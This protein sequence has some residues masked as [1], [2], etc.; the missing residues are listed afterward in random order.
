M[1]EE[2]VEYHRLV[3]FEHFW[4]YVND[5]PG[6]IPTLPQRDYITYIPYNYCLCHHNQKNMFNPALWRGLPI[7]QTPVMGECVL[8]ARNEGLRWLALNDVDERFQVTDEKVNTTNVVDYIDTL[9]F[10]DKVGGIIAN[11]VF[12]GRN[13]NV[14]ENIELAMDYSWRKKTIRQPKCLIIA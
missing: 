10:K 4:V 3:G 7:F 12:F 9:P 11:G 1:L 14:E 2:W 8:R 6:V 13:P 5:D